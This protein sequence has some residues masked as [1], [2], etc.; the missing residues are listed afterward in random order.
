MADQPI[1]YGAVRADLVAR[2]AELDERR[3]ELDGAIAA[4]EKI[5]VSGIAN[6]MASRGATIY[7]QPSSAGMFKD[8]TIVEAARTYLKSTKNPQ[9]AR[10]IA[11]ALQRGGYV[12][13]SENPPNTVNAV[14][15][16]A[17]E[18]GIL[19]RLGNAVYT[20]PD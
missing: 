16:R 2:R 19:K 6:A 20:L 14:L 4:V 9:S 10:Q 13:G 1:D 5:L 7:D 11:D 18:K 12:F 17:S 8:A 3:R 15:Y